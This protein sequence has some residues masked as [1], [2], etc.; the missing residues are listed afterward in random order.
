MSKIHPIEVKKVLKELYHKSNQF[1]TKIEDDKSLLHLKGNGKY[2]KFFFKITGYELI[3]G[4]IEGT[5]MVYDFRFR[6]IT[7]YK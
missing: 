6:V 2:Q 7:C 1:I 3:P 4:I 5:R